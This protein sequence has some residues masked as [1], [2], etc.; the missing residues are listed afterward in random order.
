MKTAHELFDFCV[1][2]VARQ[3]K[4]SIVRSPRRLPNGTMIMDTMGV[5]HRSDGLKCIIGPLIPDGCYDPSIEGSA[6][7]NPKVV[8]C[9]CNDAL[10][11]LHLCELMQEAYDA[12]CL[13]THENYWCAPWGDHGIAKELRFVAD[14]LGLDSSVLAECWPKV[15][16]AELCLKV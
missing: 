15:R 2:E 10:E 14:V 7:P 1:R 13:H 3:T 16:T 9:L 8:S 6:L 5:Y 11:H 4:P 12:A